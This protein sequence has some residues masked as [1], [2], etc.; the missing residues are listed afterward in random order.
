MNFQACCQISKVLR[1]NIQ[2]SSAGGRLWLRQ[3]LS[4][5]WSE[6]W[7]F[8]TDRRLRYWI[9]SLDALFEVDLRKTM[10]IKKD[11]NREYRCQH[12]SRSDHGPILITL[13]GR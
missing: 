5:E 10:Q 4:D 8:V 1:S 3:N 2:S 6:G 9:P 7:A 12:L 11:L 13:D